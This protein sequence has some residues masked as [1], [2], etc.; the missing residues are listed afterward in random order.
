MFGIRR[1]ARVCNAIAVFANASDLHSQA[2]MPNVFAEFCV[3]YRAYSFLGYC[4]YSVPKNEN[5]A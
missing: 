2:F 3:T 1:R 4:T 5:G